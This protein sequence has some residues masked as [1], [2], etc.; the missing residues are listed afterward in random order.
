MSIYK[1]HHA[2]HTTTY[3]PF[4]NNK[5]LQIYPLYTQPISPISSYTIMAATISPQREVEEAKWETE[6]FRDLSRYL[7]N[8]NKSLEWEIESLRAQN[9]YLTAENSWLRKNNSEWNASETSAKAMLDPTRPVFVPTSPAKQTT[10]NAPAP[11]VIPLHR[12]VAALRASRDHDRG[13]AIP[14]GHGF[15]RNGG[16]RNAARSGVR[17]GATSNTSQVP[18]AVKKVPHGFSPLK[19]TTTEH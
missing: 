4:Y 5:P 2:G 7:N 3:N 17:S 8:K 16:L 14:A 18:R 10:K 6:V 9:T 13:Q 19:N 11:R 1:Y 12:R 15:S